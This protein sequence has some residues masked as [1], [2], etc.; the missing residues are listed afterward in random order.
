M[1]TSRKAL[2]QA[3]RPKIRIGVLT[4]LSGQYRDN[5]GPTT[6]LAAKQAVEDFKPADHGFDVEIVS[7]DHQQKTRH[8]FRRGSAVVDRDGGDVIADLNNTAIALAASDIAAEKNKT[9]LISGA[10]SADLTGKYCS[11]NFVHW[12][13]DT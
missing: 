12:S 1:F 8:R 6:V 10:A 4:D 13:P 9:L 2:A 5:S 11:P 7:A 3:A